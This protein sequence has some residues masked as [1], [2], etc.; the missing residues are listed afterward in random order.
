MNYTLH[1]YSKIIYIM[2]TKALRD[3]YNICYVLPID[4]K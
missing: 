4:F 1:I 3:V 2:T